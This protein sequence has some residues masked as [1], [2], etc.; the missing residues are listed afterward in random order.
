MSKRNAD[1]ECVDLVT[2]LQR[3]KPIRQRL[4]EV[5]YGGNERQRVKDQFEDDAI[6]VIGPFCLLETYRPTKIENGGWWRRVKWSSNEG[7]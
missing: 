1:Y 6:D 2:V 4:F 5:L 7:L 3:I